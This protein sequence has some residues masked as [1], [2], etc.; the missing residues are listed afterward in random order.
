MN[1]LTKLAMRI[2]ERKVRAYDRRQA[3]AIA[4]VPD[5]PRFDTVVCML[6]EKSVE[7]G[8]ACRLLKS[9]LT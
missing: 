8:R 4:D 1:H 2:I 6:E 3:Q 7:L 5:D 9:E